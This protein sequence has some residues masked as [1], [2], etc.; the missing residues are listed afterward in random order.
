MNQQGP[1]VHTLPDRAERR[2]KRRR[3]VRAEEVLLLALAAAI[4]LIYGA[5]ISATS[6]HAA[7]VEYE[8]TIA[9]TNNAGS[10]VAPT[11]LAVTASGRRAYVGAG[12]DNSLLYYTISDSG[13]WSR[14]AAYTTGVARPVAVEAN[15]DE[16]RVYVLGDPDGTSDTLT[17]YSVDS[18]SGQLTHA[19]THV[20]GQDGVTGLDQPAA[21]AV[22]PDD[23]HVYVTARGDHRVLLFARQT[24]GN[25]MYAGS[26]RDGVNGVDGLLGASR[27]VVSPDGKH[28]YVTA[29]LEHALTVFTRDAST[30]A[31]EFLATLRD[32]VDGVDG[33]SGAHALAIS[34]DGA[35]VYVGGLGDNSVSLFRC[36]A[37]SG[38][39]TPVQV[40]RNG[41]APISGLAQVTAVRISPDANKLYAVSAGDDALV[42]FAR[43]P[44]SGVLSF[45]G[46]LVDA[47]NGVDGLQDTFDLVVDGPG[48]HIYSVNG[49]NR[50]GQF[51]V[52][53]LDLAL[54]LNSSPSG[55]VAPSTPVT[56]TVSV[57][58]NGPLAA[59]GVVVD[60]TIDGTNAPVSI[61]AEQGSCYAVPGAQRCIIGGLAASSGTTL[62]FAAT[63]ADAGKVSIMARANADQNDNPVDNSAVASET[64]FNSAPLATA[65]VF[66]VN[67]GANVELD[68][69]A[70]DSDADRG[71]NVHVIAVGV[72]KS[73]TAERVG[74]R[75]RYTAPAAGATQ[76]TF[77]YTVVDD[78]GAQAQAGVTIHI[79]TPPM[80]AN[81]HVK[82]SVDTAVTVFVLAND[83]DA[84]VADTLEVTG[85]DA[86]SA[87]G[88]AV[89]SA[90]YAASTATVMLTYNPPA[91]FIGTDTFTYQVGDGRSGLA[92]G[93]VTIEVGSA[94][95]PL[96][97]APAVATTST[98]TKGGGAIEMLWIA[99]F[100][101]VALCRRRT[102]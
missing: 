97:Q 34:A 15:R 45:A 25:L 44:R 41:T 22:S 65:D 76:D 27:I 85:F 95:Q 18:A 73:G 102:A 71:D 51:R 93:T 42:T 1:E 89:T 91:G 11:A 74:D 5:L 39:V 12:L 30:G 92:T 72:A 98:R 77:T 68:V 6:A 80:A 75:V 52:P 20:N 14:V 55:L 87:R 43:D 9:V 99:L 29:V 48:E 69:L 33:L 24:G 32:G 50:I 13:A 21:L 54:A 94:L 81:D 35:H 26:V 78:H 86:L 53:T 23:R 90:R 83:I 67:L 63:R 40:Y 59:T 79:N 38:T 2:G 3:R 17:E 60:I 10:L 96:T 88:G 37:V 101:G 7:G 56:Y 36:D 82:T 61:T 16:T 70:N 19:R 46:K 8:A 100:A 58:N 49:E 62:S 66:Y 84:N 47:V 28:V 57:T 4:V 64:T 31:L